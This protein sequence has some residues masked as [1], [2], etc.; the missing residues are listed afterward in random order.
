MLVG[1]F[2]DG[3]DKVKHHLLRVQ[4]PEKRNVL[5]AITAQRHETTAWVLPRVAR[6]PTVSS[7][8]IAA[9]SL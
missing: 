6:G 9:D 4:A 2:V 7:D 5:I 8:G 1:R 3:A